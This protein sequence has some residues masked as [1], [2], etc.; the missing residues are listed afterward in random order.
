M[1]KIEIVID[2]VVD[3]FEVKG[4]ND[5]KVVAAVAIDHKVLTNYKDM[6]DWVDMNIQHPFPV[7][8]LSAQVLE[9]V[10]ILEKE[11]I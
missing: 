11:S 8:L 10:F 1:S 3:I 5:L 4:I 7:A 2:V 9:D 6:I